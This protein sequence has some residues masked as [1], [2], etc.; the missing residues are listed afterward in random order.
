VPLVYVTGISGS[1]KSSVLH[2]L[3]RRGYEAFGVDE[4]GYGR[5]LDPRTGEVRSFPVDNTTLDPHEWYA[6]HD[7]VLD[8]TKVAE[9][10]GQVD[11]DRTLVF[12]CGV[13]AGEAEAWE[14][15]DVVCALVID[16]ATIR[17]R[18][19]LREGNWYGKR[20][21]ELDQILNWNVGYA[22]TY[23]TFGA[24]I[25]DAKEPLPVVV[26]A[27]IGAAANLDA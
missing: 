12:L 22:E 24:V 25:I 8:I 7:W 6:D 3:R 2:E 15:F 10:K 23:R 4:N 21:L 14:Y 13:A 16:E 1:G 20:P 9:L 17:S 26:E 11:R 27:V 19:D 5:W 18:I